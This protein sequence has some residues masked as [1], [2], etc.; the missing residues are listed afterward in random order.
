MRN[1]TKE[2]WEEENKYVRGGKREGGRGRR[3]YLKKDVCE[4]RRERE[5]KGGREE[6]GK[7]R[8]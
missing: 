6:V 8:R 1:R 7:E 5:R 3:G 4:S 2:R